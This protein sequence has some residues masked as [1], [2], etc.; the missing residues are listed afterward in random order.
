MLGPRIVHPHTDHGNKVMAHTVNIL[1]NLN[2]DKS[3]FTVRQG[4]GGYYVSYIQP[5]IPVIED[6]SKISF[7]L[8]L[9]QAVVL[10]ATPA[11]C[12]VYWGI[13][14]IPLVGDY[15]AGTSVLNLTGNPEYVYLRHT[16]T[17]GNTEIK[18]IAGSLPVTDST[19]LVIPIASYTP[20]VNGVYS[21]T[22]R[23]WKGG[24]VTYGMA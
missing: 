3:Q 10:T 14:H 8:K 6:E 2:F 7:G 12:T 15:T 16:W 11:T 19:W 13:L 20:N 9:T 24:D 1:R 22:H 17:H 23:Y 4:N 21:L 18:N 5:P